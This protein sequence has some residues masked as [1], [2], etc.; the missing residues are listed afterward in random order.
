[1][2]FE[3]GARVRDER[4]GGVEAADGSE[5]ELGNED[6]VVGDHTIFDLLRS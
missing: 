5:V 3:R 1:M 6:V 2:R 4:R